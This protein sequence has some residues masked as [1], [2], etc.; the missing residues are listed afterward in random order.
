[1]TSGWYGRT[2]PGEFDA[3][4]VSSPPL[5][6]GLTGVVLARRFE[7]RL[8]FEV[9]DLWPETAVDVGVFRS[10]SMMEKSWSQMAEFI[11]RRTDAVIAVTQD[12]HV[13]LLARGLPES[14]VHFVPNGVD[15]ELVHLDAPDRRA[16]LGLEDKFV[17]LFAGLI[18]VMQN[19]ESIVEAAALLSQYQHI[20]FLIVGDGAM[21]TQVERRIAELELENITLLPPQPRE[22]MPSFLNTAD[23][24]L[25]TLAKDVRGAVPYKLLE[26]WAYQKPI[27]AAIGDEGAQL[28]S[29]CQGGLTAPGDDPKALARAVLELSRDME[30]GR[31]FGQNGRRCIE[32]RLNREKLAKAMESVLKEITSTPGKRA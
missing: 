18:G 17:A 23:V 27:I 2:L 24:C 1:M 9:R 12:I 5:F 26:A 32:S 31:R 21:R 4:V 3:I 28:V 19:V 6:L 29:A 13:R 16:A 8:V 7:A 25:A 11:Y 22:M 20:H 10:G 14:K 30:A 15:L